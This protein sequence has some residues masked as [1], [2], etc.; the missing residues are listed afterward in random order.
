MHNLLQNYLLLS[1]KWQSSE[2][3]TEIPRLTDSDVNRYLLNQIKVKRERFL[4]V[5]RKVEW[6]LSRLEEFEDLKDN[7]DSYGAEPI[8]PFVIEEARSIFKSITKIGSVPTS[9]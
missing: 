7:W 1:L 2:I 3:Q 8:E 5:H 6:V 4:K 9:L